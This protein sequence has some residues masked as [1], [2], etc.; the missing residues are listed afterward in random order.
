LSV[1][2]VGSVFDFWE[3][4]QWLRVHPFGVIWI[5]I[6]DPRPLRSWCIKGT[7]ESTVVTD[8]LVPLMN[9]DPSDLGSRIL[10]QVIPKECTLIHIKYD[11]Q[12][13]KN[14]KNVILKRNYK[15]FFSF[16]IKDISKGYF[17]DLHGKKDVC[18]TL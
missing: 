16:R 18:F 5:R 2:L 1:P 7:D 9:Y 8:S 10:I 14:V 15:L 4:S 12:N 3:I 13:L 17:A 6:T 11:L